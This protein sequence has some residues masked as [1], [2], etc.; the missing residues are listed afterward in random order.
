M[1]RRR[2][3]LRLVLSS[4]MNGV[5]QSNLPILPK[6]FLCR[7]LVSRP[8][9][10]RRA[11]QHLQRRSLRF[12]RGVVALQRRVLPRLPCIRLV[13]ILLH[14]PRWYVLPI[15]LTLARNSQLSRNGTEP[16]SLSSVCRFE[17][18]ESERAAR[19]LVPLSV[20][21]PCSRLQSRPLSCD[22]LIANYSF[23]ALS[24]PNDAARIANER[25]L[26][27]RALSARSCI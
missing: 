3:P 18:S 26:D 24:H 21:R 25:S 1:D 27:A 17:S 14:L 20:P 10:M 23:L 2:L 7:K 16:L 15:R 19:P 5:S 12:N 8:M 6:V 13:H 4:R 22:M 9:R 11:S